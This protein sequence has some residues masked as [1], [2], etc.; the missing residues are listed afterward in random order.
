MA[1]GSSIAFIFE[2]EEKKILFGADAFPTVLLESL[3][4]L[5]PDGNV[6]FDAVKVP[7]HGSKGNLNH[8]LL[9]KINCSNYL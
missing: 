6:S 3:E 2:Y 9:E 5:S 7:H 1:N 8:S 4:R